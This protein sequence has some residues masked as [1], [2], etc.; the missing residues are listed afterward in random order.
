MKQLFLLSLL[1]MTTS[2]C[3]AGLLR[4]GYEEASHKVIKEAG[5]IQLR[6]YPALQLIQTEMTDSRDGGFMRLFRYIDKGNEK[7]QKIAMTTPVFVEMEDNIRKM[8]FVLPAEM[9]AEEVPAPISTKLSHVQTQ[10]GLYATYRY[11]GRVEVSPKEVYEKLEAWMEANGYEQKG[12][13]VHAFYDPPWTPAPMR[14]NELLIPVV[15]K[16][17][18]ATAQ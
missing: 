7:E 8:S 17:K 14:R 5:P 15:R 13:E 12:L 4:Q 9:K 10:P 11:N 6:E 16:E 18:K 1:L 2:S 3:S